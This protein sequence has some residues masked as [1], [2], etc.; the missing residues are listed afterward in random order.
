MPLRV[1]LYGK[2]AGDIDKDRRG[3][4]AFYPSK[5][6]FPLGSRALSLSIPLYPEVTRRGVS[7][8]S[9]EYGVFFESLL[10]QG[11]SLKNI[12]RQKQLSE[13]DSYGL[14]KALGRDVAG[15]VQIFDPEDPYEQPEPFLEKVSA[16]D[17]RSMLHS[18]F[19]EPLGNTPMTGMMSLGGYQN[20]IMLVQDGN[21]WNRA[22]N[23]HAT[24]H[25]IKPHAD[26]EQIRDIIYCEAYG[27]D[28]A[29]A[30][31]V[32]D[33]QSWIEDF[34]GEDALVIER[35]D[36][37]VN[38][39]FTRIHQEN[40]LQAMGL[41]DSAKYEMTNHGAVSLKLFAK[42]LRSHAGKKAQLELLGT[43]VVNTAIGNLDAHA[44]NLGVLHLPDGSIELAPAYDMVPNTH[45]LLGGGEQPLALLVGGEY[46]H[47][48]VSLKTLIAEG[49]SWGVKEPQVRAVVDEKLDLLR[50]AFETIEPH[51][52]MP[53]E[54]YDNVGQYIE[55]LLNGK[56]VG[57]ARH[58]VIPARSSQQKLHV[59]ATK[60]QPKT[61]DAL[62]LFPVKSAGNAPCIL[63]TLHGGRHRS[64]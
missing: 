61:A 64:R 5:G 53:D 48:Y 23:G 24:T 29:R 2:H 44:G 6:I 54:A 60:K 10:P 39:E 15:A 20:K 21:G 59:P 4:L 62:C 22:H 26:H 9:S 45:Y 19:S 30:A 32:L 11:E 31:G 37:S 7:G 38:G 14:L 28:L 40:A 57:S 25:I 51:E 1:E 52:A 50:E 36:R 17:I 43:T 12:A 34:D 3:N 42:L 63:K 41:T 55:N 27:L 35:F 46:K 8:K 56:P 18:T 49:V 13:N 33:Y 58:M 16:S 47:K